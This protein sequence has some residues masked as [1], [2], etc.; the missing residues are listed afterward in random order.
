MPEDVFSPVSFGDISAGNRLVMCP[1]TRR[2]ADADGTPNDLMREYYRQRASAGLIVTESVHPSLVG[3]AYSGSPH[4][5]TGRDLAAWALVVEAVHGEGG[6]IVLQ[7]MHAG[8]AARTEVNGGRTPLAPSAVA[9]RG[10]GAPDGGRPVPRALT[11]GEI[12]AT[13]EEFAR[14]AHM[15]MEAGFDGVEIHGG[16]SYLLHQFL[17]SG[18][19][20][21]TDAHGG[22]AENRSLFP[23]R[24]VEAVAGEVG[25]GRVG[26]RLS[27][28]FSADRT[29]R[30]DASDVYSAL[31]S[32]PSVRRLAY[33]HTSSSSDPDVLAWIRAHWT[34]GW[35]H[36]LGADPELSSPEL[37]S[38]IESRLGAGPNAVSLGRLFISNPD[39]PERLL[40]GAPIAVPNPKNFYQGESEGYTDY[41]RWTDK[42]RQPIRA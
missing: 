34:G 27:P 3:K 16:N 1:M 35:I 13:V 17:G 12:D 26:L 11:G 38:R 37:L 7:L 42:D 39:L 32:H 15:A 24:V 6:R 40:H 29:V 20:L 10:T 36:N 19:N 28:G 5:I 23:V 31:L 25:H 8:S 30:G 2:R 18:T 9:P 21:R 14:A 41:E 4:L 33:L 22:S